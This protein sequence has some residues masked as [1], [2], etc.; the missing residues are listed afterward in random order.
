V[1]RGS[2]F[3]YEVV[4]ELPLRRLGDGTSAR[5]SLA[6]RRAPEPIEPGRGTEVHRADRHGTTF[7]LERVGT[8]LAAHCSATGSYLIDAGARSLWVDPDAEPDDAWEHRVVSMAFPLLAAELGDAVLHASAVAVDGRAVAFVGP[9]G[10][11]KSSIA[12]AASGFDLLGEDGV[13]VSDGDH[14]P[15]VWPGPR[16]VRLHGVA[17][18]A[19]QLLVDARPARL[20]AALGALVL[21]GERD[22]ERLRLEPVEAARAVPQLVPALIFGG[23]DRL[24]VAFSHAARLAA[25]TPVFAGRFPD[26]LDRLDAALEEVVRR[27]LA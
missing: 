1:T 26:D 18:K 2:L 11:G 23:S 20:P 12:A 22:P 8:A 5:G 3:G 14:G 19:T 25:T 27:V 15:I 24:A 21:L 4:S 16:G 10:R 17:G 7:V 13:A 9:P 6:L